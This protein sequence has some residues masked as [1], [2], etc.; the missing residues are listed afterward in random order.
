MPAPEERPVGE[1]VL[2]RQELERDFLEIDGPIDAP[3]RVALWPGL[4]T[5]NAGAGDAQE[6]ALCRLNSLWVVEPPSAPELDAWARLELGAPASLSALDA[7]LKQPE[8]TAVDARQFAACALALVHA[9][10]LP[11]GVAARLPAIQARLEQV[12]AKLPVRAT[13]LL[14]Y[15][16]SQLAGSDA[17]GLARTRDR[18]LQR[19]VEEGLRPE[20]DLPFFLRGAGLK[21]SERLREVRDQARELHKSVRDWIGSSLK[22]S[23]SSTQQDDGATLGYVDLFFAFSLA[24]LGEATHARQL[25]ESGR[26]VL[27]GFAP[28]SKQAIAG[29]YLAKAFTSRVEAALAGRPTGGPL[30][31]ALVQE[32][33][34]IHARSQANNKADKVAGEAHYAIV[35]MRE[36]SRVLEQLE[37]LNPYSDFLKEA[38]DLRKA[39][40]DLP[41]LRDPAA[42]ARASRDLYRN[43]VGGRPTAETRFQSLMVS[44]ALAGRVG[45][46]FTLE[47]LALVPETLKGIAALP[48]SHADAL[49]DQGKVTRAGAVPRGPVRPPRGGAA[50]R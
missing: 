8:P 4:A 28:G 15:R 39:L 21:D 48:A 43:A 29:S 19:L 30:E 13:W 23:A 11:G 1:W 12:E 47:L 18:L 32:L 44:L 40:N 26:A 24:K 6:S 41:R 5:A 34:A 37:K 3:G 9:E 38:D 36:Q 46:A 49:K 14:A 31:P 20:R 16:L 25:A 42:L 27:T 7:L 33:D 22:L 50:S 17:L 35:R 10:P 45:E 2:R